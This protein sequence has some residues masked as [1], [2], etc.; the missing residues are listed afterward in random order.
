MGKT[1]NRKGLILLTNAEKLRGMLPSL[2]AD[3]LFITS[4]ENRF[5]ATEFRSSAGI[6]V[7]TA[8]KSYFF[9][10]FRY[11]EA[12][13]ANISGFEIEMVAADKKYT[14]LISEALAANNVKKLAFEDETMSVATFE[15]WKKALEVEFCPIGSAIYGLRQSKED[16]EV[17]HMVAA[18]RIAEKALSEVLPLIKPGVTEKEI[19]GELIYRMLKNGAEDMSFEPIVV[20]GANSSK[21]HGVPSDKKIEAGDFVTM[22]FGCRYMGYCSDMT[23]T[24]AVGYAT[25]E[26]KKVYETVLAAQHAGLAASRAGVSGK[27][28]DSAARDVITAAGYGEHFGHS[29]GHSL[30][31]EIHEPPNAAQSVETLMPV[32]AVV[33]AE[34]GIY[35]PGKFGVRIEDVVVMC[36]NGCENITLAKKD[37]IIL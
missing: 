10:D 4:P 20:S 12:A 36:E 23:R 16:W 8:E 31:I 33:S 17:A 24:V 28:I 7:I 30:G 6:V 26:M 9:T 13:R 35:I 34:P 25:D 32:G 14:V 37:L 18:Q 22:D 27:D 11:I 15:Q 3:A 21:P 1:I 29:Y 19:A 5:Y 2:S